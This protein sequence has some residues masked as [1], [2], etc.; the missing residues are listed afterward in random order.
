M[1]LGLTLL[2]TDIRSVSNSVKHMLGRPS[3][4]FK[5]RQ[6][7]LPIGTRIAADIQD[8]IGVEQALCPSSRTQCYRRLSIRCNSH[9]P[10]KGAAEAT[11]FLDEAVSPR[12]S[13]RHS[14]G[15]D[16]V[17]GASTACL[18]RRPQTRAVR[19][20]DLPCPV[21]P[22]EGRVY[23]GQVP[24][25]ERTSLCLSSRDCSLRALGLKRPAGRPTRPRG[26]SPSA[27]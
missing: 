6:K 24:T 13:M 17:A 8:V 11:P 9:G 18:L 15:P 5:A 26:T 22:H 19:M 14:L 7:S 20:D 21:L 16:R 12:I 10:Q 4:G 2:F 27:Q 3:F 23:F 25:G 1:D